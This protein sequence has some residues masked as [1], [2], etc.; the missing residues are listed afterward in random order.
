M[1]D[2]K[3]KEKCPLCGM[4]VTSDK[5]KTEY[6]GHSYY[7]CSESDRKSFA[8]NPEKYIGKSSKAA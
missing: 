5:F 2:L 1:T 3:T 4:D 7:F 6:K 8:A